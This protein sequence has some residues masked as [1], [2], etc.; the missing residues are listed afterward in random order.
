MTYEDY[1]GVYESQKQT[2]D[3]IRPQS[4]KLRRIVESAW[5]SLQRVGLTSNAPMLGKML[6]LAG[7]RCDYTLDYLKFG[8]TKSGVTCAMLLTD[9]RADAKFEASTSASPSASVVQ[10]WVAHEAVYLSLMGHF[11]RLIGFV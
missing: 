11:T 9:S 2:D 6:S 4:S 10:A 3:R 7:Q 8:P 1:F 5:S